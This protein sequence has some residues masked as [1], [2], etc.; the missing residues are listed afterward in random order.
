MPDAFIEA[1]IA[2][3]KALMMKANLEAAVKEEIAQAETI[4]KRSKKK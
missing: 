1:P 2:V 4:N 3:G